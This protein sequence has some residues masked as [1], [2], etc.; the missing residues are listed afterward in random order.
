MPNFSEGRNLEKVEGIVAALKNVSGITLLNYCMDQDHN[1]AV[2]TFIGE[3]EA[4]LAGAL[5]ACHEA[6]EII[7][8]RLH[9]GEHPRIGAVDVVPFIPLAGASMADAVGVAHRFGRTFG[10]RDH[11]S[12]Y[13]Y[14]EAAVDGRRENLADIRRGGY[15]RLR[16]KMTKPEWRP[17]TGNLVFNERIGA[18]A[19]GARMPLIAFNINLRTSDKD[20]ARTIASAIRESGGGLP[21]VKAIGVYLGS[22]HIAQVSMNL[23]NF[24]MTSLKTVFNLVREKAQ[25]LG[26]DILESEL[27]GLVPEEALEDTT[28]EYLMIDG[29]TKERILETHVPA[30]FR[31]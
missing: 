11:A 8:M 15:E 22:R 19:V 12:V 20:I 5:A 2:L 21:H 4:V 17:D 27:I 18:T 1:R 25:R 13:F 31:R 23:T 24:K 26:T 28:P 6:C 7:D 14:G 3:P 29:F 9:K 16:E 30:V 10:E